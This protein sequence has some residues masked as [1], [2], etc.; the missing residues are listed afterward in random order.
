MNE[1]ENMSFKPG[2]EPTVLEFYDS[3][4]KTPPSDLIGSE[5]GFNMYFNR[6]RMWGHALYFAKLS[7][8]SHPYSDLLN[9]YLQSK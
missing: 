8:Y 5:E 2:K 7:S 1:H 3:T 4:S 9:N 6:E